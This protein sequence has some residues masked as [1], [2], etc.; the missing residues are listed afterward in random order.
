MKFN[1]G[2]EVKFEGNNEPCIIYRVI[3]PAEVLQHCKTLGKTCA[4]ITIEV[5]GLVPAECLVLAHGHY[6]NAYALD[7]KLNLNGQSN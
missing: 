4:H 7:V 5:M 6:Q 3:D 1:K 2:D